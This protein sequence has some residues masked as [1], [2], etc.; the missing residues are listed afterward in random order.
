M[1][2]FQQAVLFSLLIL[3]HAILIS[4]TVLLVRKRAF[5]AKFK[6]VSDE[7]E[8]ERSTRHSAP[9]IELQAADQEPAQECT[10]S[11]LPGESSQRQ[12]C[13][14][15]SKAS[16]VVTEAPEETPG[17]GEHPWLDDDQ[18]TVSGT[19]SRLH[20]Q[21]R[22]FP[23]AGIGARPDLNNHPRDAIPT[24]PLFG[25]ESVSGLKSILR[26]T[27]KYMASKG[28][29]SRNSQF[30]DLTA[31]EREELGGVEY[32]A[33]SFLSVVVFLYFILFLIFGM[34][35]VGGWLEVND[36]AVTRTNGLSPFWTG[37]FFAVSAFV[38]SGMSL[39]DANM[40]ALQLRYVIETLRILKLADHPSGLTRF[41]QWDC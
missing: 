6:G 39:L 37:A 36:P 34:I 18:I 3:G 28:L 25:D 20:H 31:A 5:E 17:R 41:L 8:R 38:N 1:N 26:G 27:Q 9:E 14:P 35:G 32:K 33:V 40:T 21:H 11:D 22:V 13:K 29:V 19:S 30:H 23:M 16:V 15:R 7:R 2:S 4:L 10:G 24:M 12:S